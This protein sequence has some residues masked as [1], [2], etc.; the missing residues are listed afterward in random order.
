M[1]EPCAYSVRNLGTGVAIYGEEFT[2][3]GRKQRKV[4]WSMKVMERQ[5]RRERM[6]RTRGEEGPSA[7]A[8]RLL[9]GRRW[10]RE[11]CARLS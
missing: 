2:S 7:R 11:G 9:D 10:Y 8:E 6:T 3:G 1:L 5:G 4:L